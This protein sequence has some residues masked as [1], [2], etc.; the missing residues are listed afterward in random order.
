MTR[1]AFRN[2]TCA[3]LAVIGTA[4][5]PG[6][7]ARAIDAAT[8][9]AACPARPTARP[10]TAWRRPAAGIFRHDTFGDEQL[11]TDALRLHDIVA[12]LSPATALAVGLKV[13]AEALPS[14]LVAALR[15][16]KVDL[17][18]PA[19]TVEPPRLD[20]LMLGTS[21]SGSLIPPPPQAR[22]SAP[23]RC[24]A[25]RR[26]RRTAGSRVHVRQPA[27]L[28]QRCAAAAPRSSSR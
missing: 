24:C 21:S 10:G 7:A 9:L 22:P 4:V 12:T 11:W 2:A 26:W 28:G 8:A 5:W 1:R 13:D 20:S 18:S 17:T 25:P 27:Q 23:P 19:V 16:G 15:A 3:T 14:G 6:R